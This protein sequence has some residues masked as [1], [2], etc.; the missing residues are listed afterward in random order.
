MA[1]GGIAPATPSTRETTDADLRA[2]I[3]VLEER[4]QELSGQL[5]E[6]RA[7]MDAYASSISHDLRSPLGAILTFAAI[8]SEDHAARLD[9]Q[10]REWLGRISNSARTAVSL[11][12]VVLEFLSIG[13]Q[14]VRPAECDVEAIVDEVVSE[15]ALGDG[16][17]R[18]RITVGSLPA[19]R[20]DPA[21]LKI[22]FAKLVSNAVRFSAGAATPAI[23]ID[24]RETAERWEYHVVDS[25]MGFEM[26]HAHR[27]FGLFERLHA[28]HSGH[29]VGLAIAERI[30]RRHGGRIWAESELGR[31]ATF[32]FHLPR[33]AAARP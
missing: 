4:I 31:G 24:G 8:L 25:G 10:G 32:S 5:Q 20:A 1:T 2:R 19:C 3:R 9:D 28:R 33:E 13:R 22:L 7:D 30:V 29:G 26:K 21:L 17:P 16:A 18:P 14:P 27:L 15:L 6:A 12:D 11:M 23:Q